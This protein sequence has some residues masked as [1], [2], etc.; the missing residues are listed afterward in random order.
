[1]FLTIQEHIFAISKLKDNLN[2]KDILIGIIITTR[3]E[4]YFTLDRHVI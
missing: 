1:M 3:Y 4:E 2:C